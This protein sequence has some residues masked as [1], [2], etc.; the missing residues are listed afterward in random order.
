[1][2]THWGFQQKSIRLKDRRRQPRRA[3]VLKDSQLAKIDEE[4]VAAFDEAP[5]SAASEGDTP[6]KM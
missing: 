5:A 4:L 3:W 6:P 2:L 1:L